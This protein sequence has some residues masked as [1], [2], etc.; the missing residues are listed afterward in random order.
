[1]YYHSFL[2]KN[3]KKKLL[4]IILIN[5]SIIALGQT[6]ING[7]INNNTNWTVEYS[8][9]IIT[10][11]TLVVNGITLTIEAGVS[12]KFNNNT[13]MQVNGELKAIGTNENKITFSSNNTSQNKG[14]WNHILFSD[15]SVDANYD[16][17]GN[18]Q[19]GSIIKYCDFSYGGGIDLGI[20]NINKS[21]PHIEHS[22]FSNSS[23]DGIYINNA[24]P[25]IDNCTISNNNGAGVLS[26]KYLYENDIEISNSTINKNVGGGIQIES[27]G[28]GTLKFINNNIS[29]NSKNAIFIYSSGG[30]GSGNII[31]ENNTINNNSNSNGASIFIDGGFDVDIKCNTITNNTG[32]S[33]SGMY[34]RR[35]YNPYTLNITNNLISK[36]ISTS[37]D[38]IHLDFSYSYPTTLNFHDNYITDNNSQ[39]TSVINLIGHPN[40]S[41]FDVKRNTFTKNNGSNLFKLKWFKGSISN[42]NIFENSVDY[43][44]YNLNE[45]TESTIN[46]KNNFW[47]TSDINTINIYDWFDNGS[48]SIVEL[49]PILNIATN[50][51]NDNDCVHNNLSISDIDLKNI[52]YL[53]WPNP[54]DDKFKISA[55]S[56]ENLSLEIEIYSIRGNLIKKQSIENYKEYITIQRGSLTSG[57]YL[58]RIIIDNKYTSTV[59]LIAK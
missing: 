27:S 22:T 38:I 23:S 8:P 15:S 49:N 13:T 28:N 36:N 58:C 21:Q 35:G 46:A 56:I 47:G 30:S 54:F 6:S 2:K 11:N 41:I 33:S 25:K 42:N 39:N 51:E 12:I 57:I 17:G 29:N 44:I 50:T 18:Y 7:L 1:L 40:L 19:S 43:L 3:M 31:I 34:I 32:T 37:G 14:D 4:F 26:P 10:G 20:L 53:I 45:A 48:L 9:Y 24:N 16:S 5:I 55:N 59:K 52:E